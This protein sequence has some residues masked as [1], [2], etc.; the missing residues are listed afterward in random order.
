M[1]TKVFQWS[2]HKELWHW[3][4]ANP[5][6]PKGHW[7]QWKHNGGT[8]DL[9]EC[10]CF[11]CEYSLVDDGDYTTDCDVCPLV[12]VKNDK[13]KSHCNEGG[14]WNQWLCTD[15]TGNYHELRS[16]LALTIAELPVKAGVVCV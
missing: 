2:L 15:D 5:M 11:A 6:Q 8:V 1:E 4:A 7:P 9:V 12:W 14:L 3:L 10:G 16:T 13:G